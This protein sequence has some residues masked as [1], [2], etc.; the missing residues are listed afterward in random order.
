MPEERLDFPP[1][2]VENQIKDQAKAHHMSEEEVVEKVLL[3][4]QAVKSF[5]PI[6]KLGEIA[7]FLAAENATTVSGS[8][9]TLDGAWSAQ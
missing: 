1:G 2:L 3:E 4:K 9:F 7:V 8:I 5:V 6:E